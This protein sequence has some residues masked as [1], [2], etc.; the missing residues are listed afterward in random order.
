[1]KIRVLTLVS[2]VGILFSAVWPVTAQTNIDVVFRYVPQPGE[3]FVGVFL[4]GEFNGWGPNS[5]G[6]IA[7]GA[8][9]QMSFDA[10]FSQWLY[11]VS[12]QVRSQPYSYKVHYH[13]NADGSD[14][15]WI[16]DPLNERIDAADNNNSLVTVED[17]M[18]F[19]L[20]RK[21]N[22]A[23]EVTEI[24]AG[25]FGSQ[26]ITAMTFEINGA[27]Q[28][29]MPFFDS[30][31]GIFHYLLS[32]PVPGGSQFKISATDALGGVASAEVGII[33]PTV[34][35]APRPDGVRDGVNYAPADPTKVTLSLFAPGK[36]FVHVVG[37]FN[38]W[39]VDNSYL[40]NRDAAGTDS[41]HWWLEIDGLNPGQEYAYQYLV[42]GSLRI[43]DLF[44]EK[45]LDEAN[46]PFIQNTTY[47]NLKPYPTGMTQGFVS[48]L[49]TGQVRYPWDVEEFDRP[50]QGELVIYELLIRDFIA[51]HDY[52]TLADTLDY[53]DRLGINAIE[54]MPVAE[55]GGNINW[56]YQPQFVFAPDKYYG[57]ATD[58]R[59]FIDE[60]HQRGIAVILDVVYN[61]VDLPS[62]VV[63]LFG[64][65]DDN[66]WINIPARH[67]FNVFFDINHENT[68]TQYWLDR[69]NTHWL[70][71]YKVDGFRFDLSKGFTQTNT[72]SDVGAW[73]N[74]D[75]SRIRLLKRMA[76]QIWHVEPDTYVILEHFAANAEELE[77]ATWRTGE[78][79]PGMMFWNNANHRYNEATMGYNTGSN[80]NFSHA[81]YG[82]GGRNWPVPNLISYMESHDEQW[83]MFKNIEFGACANSSLGGDRCRSDPGEYNVRHLPT[84]LK[85]MKMAGAF[86]FL[87]PGPKLMFQFGE[88]GYG[89]GDAGEQCL[90]AGD[91]GDC[92]S[93]APERTGPKPIRWDYGD[94]ASSQGFL[95]TKLFKAWAALINLR[96]ENDVFRSTETVVTLNLDQGFKSI[97]LSHPTMD[98]TIVGNFDMTQ[99]E[100]SVTFTNVGRWYDFFSGAPFEVIETPMSINMQPGEFHVFTSEPVDTPEPGLV[101]T[102]TGV[103]VEFALEQNYPNP[104]NGSTTIRFTTSQPGPVRLDVFDV[105]GRRLATLVNGAIPEKTNAVIFD[106]GH[107]SSGVYLYRLQSGNRLESRYMV[108]VR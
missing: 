73:G 15:Q 84:A 34:E 32:A 33:P 105:L 35:A 98:V 20:A 104:F 19:Q 49:Q 47:A 37:D 80:S 100:S 99:R 48:V 83:L 102:S 3:N 41:T 96:N 51:D 40:M 29:G 95:R 13:L 45:I 85:R 75:A 67:P 42:N 68:Y 107:L 58:L 65:T 53:L 77:L 7:P 81:Y 103:T 36:D 27:Q 60:A 6:R 78:G 89:F 10:A 16:S 46:D 55:F 90:R 79:L 2:T 97:A 18:V 69:V 62:P 52:T 9:S 70:T 61:H 101:K 21:E 22:Q 64:A 94:E 31:K 71:E 23:G 54:L 24:S 1:M 11:S 14:N 59:R 56:G 26:S 4:P 28:D 8:V 50:P 93:S 25:V 66:P 91:S 106:A 72:G 12:L 92:P 87:L 108:L 88:L 30:G 17:P 74:V 5:G 63:G 76:D 57:P 43:A 82:P 86:F 38:D 44:S 39:R